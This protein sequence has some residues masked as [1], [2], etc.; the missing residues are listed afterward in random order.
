MIVPIGVDCGVADFCKKY[1]LRSFSL[2]FDWAVS[3]HGVSAC[4]EDEFKLFTAPLIDRV[5]NY[6]I[7][8]HHDFATPESMEVDSV[9]YR[10]R[11]KRLLDFLGGD[12]ELVFCR[13]G[14]APHNHLE[15]NGK[16][17]HICS[18]IVDAEKLDATL[19]R[20]Y[21]N[22]KFKIIVVLVCGTCFDASLT[23]TSTS[24]R[25]QVYNVVTPQACWSTFENACR[26][27]FGV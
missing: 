7:Y 26:G 12:E 27:I 14:H 16:Y 10:R 21:P 20:K 24:E 13:K 1:S 5:N 11:C 9:K 8:F 3:Y 15:H 2:P 17:A 25:V 19:R 6:D 4:I 22:L 23:Y 18:D